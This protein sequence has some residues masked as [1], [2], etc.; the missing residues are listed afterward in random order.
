MNFFQIEYFL[1]LAETLNYTK[2]SELSFISQS[3]LSRHIRSMEEELGVKLFARSTKGV[4][5]T[6][7]G[8]I[9]ARGFSA[10]NKEYRELLVRAH[11]AHNGYCEEIKMGILDGFMINNIMH[12]IEDYEQRHPEIRIELS[13]ANT[14]TDLQEMLLKKK[15]DFAFGPQT[16]VLQCPQL[17]SIGLCQNRLCLVMSVRHPLAT[18]EPDTLS[19]RDFRDETFITFSGDLNLAHRA[20]L[21]RCSRAS[22]VPKIITAP[23]L[24][25]IILW[26]EARR[27]VTCLYENSSSCGHPG[28]K[29]Q[30]LKDLEIGQGSLLW[31]S[32][33]QESRNLSFIKFLQSGRAVVT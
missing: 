14:M 1:T 4:A 8:I 28:L 10:M 32:E 11:A 16:E 19:L 30:Y 17:S 33:N 5:L 31:N 23:N 7:A 18:C 22:F 13:P 9:L 12:L 20:L 6:T 2:A 15:L 26:V 27:G 21:V 3:M 25:T 29:Y 24:S